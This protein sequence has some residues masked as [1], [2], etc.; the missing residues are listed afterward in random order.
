VKVTV[1]GEREHDAQGDDEVRSVW[2]R[3]RRTGRGEPPL[4]L[5]RIVEEAVALLDDEGI[6]RLTMRR[7]ADRLKVSAGTLYWH[8]DT[9]DD[10]IDLAVDAIFEEAPPAA[11]RKSDSA[12][13]GDPAEHWR[14]DVTAVLTAWRAAI[15]RHPWAVALPAR[16]RPSI[17]PNFLAWMEFLQATLVRAGFTDRRLLAATWALYNHVMGSTASQTSLQL[18]NQERQSAHRQLQTNRAEYPTLAAHGYL[19][20]NDWDGS[21]TTGLRY[22]LDGLQAEAHGSKSGPS[23]I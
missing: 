23:D 18:S 16:Q 6:D 14:T 21:F 17:G 20:D 10:V 8:V 11:H 5:S 7:L 1:N 19:F 2:L 22:L 3:P 4:T 13:G 12:A 15:L 9:K